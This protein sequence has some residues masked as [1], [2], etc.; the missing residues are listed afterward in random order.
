MSVNAA[1]NKPG[2]LVR[3]VLLD[4]VADLVHISVTDIVYIGA[5]LDLDVDVSAVVVVVL[6]VR[7][8]VVVVLLLS[9]ETAVNDCLEDHS[10]VGY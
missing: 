9:V 2:V 10:V 1:V 7:D 8:V 4:I 3:L 6:V 5:L